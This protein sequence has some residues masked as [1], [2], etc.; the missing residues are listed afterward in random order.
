MKTI[1]SKK[2]FIYL[3]LIVLL[4]SCNAIKIISKIESKEA[5]VISYTHQ[6]KSLK[7]IPLV[8]FGQPEFY[9]GIKDTETA[10]KKKGY[11]VF[12]EYLTPRA[13]LKTDPEGYKKELLLLRKMFDGK[14]LSTKAYEEDL[15]DLFPNA[16]GQP[17]YKNLG[18]DDNDINVDVD[19]IDVV[20]EYTK[21]FGEIA[22][23]QCDYDYPPEAIKGYPCKKL[24]NNMDP[25]IVDFRNEY[26][27]NEIHHSKNDKIVI[28]Y[29][30]NHVKGVQKLLKK[31]K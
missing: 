4:S 28:L 25:I 19:I 8:H 29:G 11:I 2:A 1:K 18:I 14:N 21:L 5:T 17:E 9:S 24:K 6:N 30:Q 26:L 12:Y 13:D 23:E 15:G 3:G 7:F 31:M 27:A 10:Y 20:E 16:I 22:L